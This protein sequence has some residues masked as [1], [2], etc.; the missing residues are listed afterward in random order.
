MLIEEQIRYIHDTLR[1][2]QQ[3][4]LDRLR[5]STSPF[6]VAEKVIDINPKVW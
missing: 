6:I 1:P 4:T 3:T 5:A 2:H